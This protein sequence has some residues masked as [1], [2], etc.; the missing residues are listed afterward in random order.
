MNNAASPSTSALP[1]GAA[2]DAA[3]RLIVLGNAAEDAGNLAEA[4]SYYRQA[5]AV[6]PRYAR[7][8]LNLGIGLESSGDADGAIAAFETAIAM[9]PANANSSYNLGRVFYSRGALPRAAELLH[10]ALRLKAGFPEAH[11]V[12]SSVLHAQGDSPGAAS[13]L[14][15]ALALRPDWSA[16]YVD[17]ALVLKE[18]GRTSDAEAA[19]R[20]ALAIDAEN[21]RASRELASLLCAKG[22]LPEA[23]RWIRHALEHR[24]DFAEACFTLSDIRDAQGDPAAAAAALERALALKPDWAQAL[25]NYGLLLQRLQRLPE[26]EAALRQAL[27]VAPELSNA[28]Q[29]LGAILINQRRIAE[30]LDVFR[31]GR[32]QDPQSFDLESAELFALNLA[33]DISSESLFA[34]HQAFG[35][36]LESAFPARFAAFANVRDEQRRLRIGYVSSDFCNHGVALFTLPLIERHDRAVCE[37]TC[38]SVGTVIDDTSHMLRDA[39]DVWRD[40]ATLSHAELADAIHRDGIDI[41]VDLAGHSGPRLPVF[42]QQ[43]APVQV[44]WLG[45]LCTTGLSRIQYRLCDA[46][47]DPEDAQR[48]HTETLVRLPGSQW[49]YRPRP[50]IDYGVFAHAPRQKNGYVTFGS[51]NHVPKLSPSVLRLWSQILLEVPDARLVL[52]GVPEGSARDGIVAHFASAGVA[53]TRLTLVGRVPLPEYFQW[54]NEVDLVLDTT[55]YSGGTT[56]CDALWMGV[57]VLTLPG[58]RP[59]SRSAAGILSVANLTEWVAAS[60]EDYVRR[61]VELARSDATIALGRDA[62]RQQMRRSPLMDEVAFARN[63]ESAYRQMWRAYCLGTRTPPVF[64]FEGNRSSP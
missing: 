15:A 7:A 59:V 1:G 35:E 46:A 5:I 41:L 12:L 58:S 64:A 30:A 48:L 36:R 17:Y 40:A 8:H 60:P 50:A 47:T 43:P 9:D 51:F 10:S 16:V 56:T 14:E 18:L 62:V 61:A 26:A 63:V 19:L 45:Y 31:R 33:E 53:T 54:F 21:A 27:A 6:A 23:E 42:A 2:T 34:R 57:P 38:Y 24:P 52:V 32:A 11:V 49:C 20:Q 37:V 25:N 44:S 3:D 13:E 29:T 4:C 22:D 55:P 39:A 28:Y